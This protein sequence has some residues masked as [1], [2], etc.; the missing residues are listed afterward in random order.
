MKSVL[1]IAV[2]L[3]SLAAFAHDTPKSNSQRKVFFTE[4]ADGAVV[5]SPLKVKFGMKGMKLCQANIAPKN[6]KCGHHH[7]LID[8]GAIASGMPIPQDEQHLHYGKMQEEAEIKLPPG[9]HTLT[10]QFADYAHLSYGENLSATITVEVKDSTAAGAAPAAG[11][12][13]SG[14]PAAPGK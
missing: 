6:K 10:L 8:K 13:G 11:A 7:L 14:A 1:S 9:K 2:F 4:P 5:T 3:V 12:T